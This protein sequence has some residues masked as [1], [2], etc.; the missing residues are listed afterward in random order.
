MS[1][2]KSHFDHMCISSTHM[3]ER[4]VF[5]SVLF[6]WWELDINWGRCINIRLLNCFGNMAHLVVFFVNN[7]FHSCT[8][9]DFCLLADMQSSLTDPDAQCHLSIRHCSISL[10]WRITLNDWMVVH[11]ESGIATAAC[12]AY[13]M[14]LAVIYYDSRLVDGDVIR[15]HIEDDTDFPLILWVTSN[16]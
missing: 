1:K 14:V 5:L 8:L 13:N 15:P 6:L 3:H 9:E 16:E 7:T 4:Q 11:L 10:T 2:I 12:E